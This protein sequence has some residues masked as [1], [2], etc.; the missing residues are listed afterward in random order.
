[1][2]LVLRFCSRQTIDRRPSLETL[3]LRSTPPQED[4]LRVALAVALN[5]L[6]ET[7]GI[8]A[9]A[10][11]VHV[12]T[13]G[14]LSGAEVCGGGELV[15]GVLARFSGG[16]DQVGLFAMET[17]EAFAMVRDDPCGDDPLGSYTALGRDLVRAV[18]TAI[19]PGGGTQEGDATLQEDAV[20]STLLRTNAPSYTAVVSLSL[21]LSWKDRGA[22]RAAQ[23]YL[24]A[25]PKPFAARLSGLASEDSPARTGLR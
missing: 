18:V 2:I 15:A 5:D 4:A 13:L 1:V 8:R 25:N 14:T 10:V 16:F 9:A 12:C 6:A 17:E 19:D 20:V 7:A 11:R 21:T 3:T 23:V 22:S 24:L